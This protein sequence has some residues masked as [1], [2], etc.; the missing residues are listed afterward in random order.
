MA[1]GVSTDGGLSIVLVEGNREARSVQSPEEM[2][3]RRR[4]RDP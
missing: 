3:G 1:Y 2:K 4:R